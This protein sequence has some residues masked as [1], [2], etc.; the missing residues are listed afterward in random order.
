MVI[1][2]FCWC[3][4]TIILN[5][6][7]YISAFTFENVWR[8]TYPLANEMNYQWICASSICLSLIF[9]QTMMA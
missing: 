5:S 7:S 6:F 3:F 8:V 4:T 9:D 2:I 1:I